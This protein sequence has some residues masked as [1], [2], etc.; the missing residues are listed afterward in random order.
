[1]R[2]SKA[3]IYLHFVWGTW[4]RSP[5]ITPEIERDLYRC[6]ESEAERLEVTVLA[7]GGVADHVHLL[8]RIP[9]RLSAANLAKQVKGV[10]STFVRDQLHPAEP[11]RWQEGYGVF[12]VSRSHVPRVITYINNQKRHHAENKLWSEWEETDEEA[13]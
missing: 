4:Q 7:I 11:F 1:M 5:F 13:D 3:E 9:T 12:S 10:S 2:R 8:V 6:I